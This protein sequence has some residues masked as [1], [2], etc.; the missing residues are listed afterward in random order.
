MN[1][2]RLNIPI[3]VPLMVA[4]HHA[5]DEMQKMTNN[6]SPTHGL[7]CEFVNDLYR[8]VFNRRSHVSRGVILAS[9][10]AQTTKMVIG[11]GGCYFT[12]TSQNTGCMFIW[13]DRRYNTFVFYALEPASVQTA[14]RTIQ[15]R[16]DTVQRRLYEEERDAQAQQQQ[17]FSDSY[18]ERIESV[19]LDDTHFQWN[20]RQCN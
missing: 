11:K 2:S 9:S 12:L 20:P 19:K 17:L 4:S 1:C 15:D 14:M 13:H 8:Q 7:T 16:I 6:F 5:W 10:N 18:R 3:G